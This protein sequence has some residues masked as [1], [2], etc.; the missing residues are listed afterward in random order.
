M[1][2]ESGVFETSV[3]KDG[4]FEISISQESDISLD[5]GYTFEDVCL[6]YFISRTNAKHLINELKSWIDSK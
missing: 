3:D 1:K 5:G 6:S 2:I 4:D